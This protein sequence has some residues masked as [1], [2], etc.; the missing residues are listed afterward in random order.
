MEAAK[1]GPAPDAQHARLIHSEASAILCPRL[2]ANRQPLGASPQLT[3][4]VEILSTTGGFH[5]TSRDNTNPRYRHGR[6]SCWSAKLNVRSIVLLPIMKAFRESPLCSRFESSYTT[7]FHRARHCFE[8]TAT[9]PR[10][11]LAAKA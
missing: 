6:V 5:E 8:T 7:H 3:S 2:S 4:T 11:G 9:V 10:I 1:T